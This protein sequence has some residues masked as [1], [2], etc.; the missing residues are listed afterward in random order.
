MKRFSSFVFGVVF[1]LVPQAAS[2]FEPGS[3]AASTTSVRG[4]AP[5]TAGEMGGARNAGTTTSMT[6]K[7]SPTQN[8]INRKIKIEQEHSTHLGA[9]PGPGLN[10]W[11]VSMER[12]Q[13]GRM[14]QRE[15][16]QVSVPIEK[17]RLPTGLGEAAIRARLVAGKVGHGLLASLKK[18][19]PAG[20]FTT[21]EGP[22]GRLFARAS[23]G[24]LWTS[25]TGRDRLKYYQLPPAPEQGAAIPPGLVKGPSGITF[26]RDGKG[27]LYLP[28]NMKRDDL[29]QDDL[30]P[31]P[32]PAK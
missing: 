18:D 19:A 22:T 7:V 14:I 16:G 28:V 23:D 11:M 26:Y 4:P 10:R 27:L 30:P 17:R 31:A 9:A 24:S 3:N 8:E 32:P 15:D 29:T 5:P 1:V 21:L 25:V 6:N 20:D 13:A 12:R 2:A